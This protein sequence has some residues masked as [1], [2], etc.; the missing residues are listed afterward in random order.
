MPGCPTFVHRFDARTAFAGPFR[1]GIS[2]H[3]HTMYSKE[4]LGRL[5]T[6]IAKF[7]IGGYIIEREL[8]RLHLYQHW[9]F[10]FNRIY[11]TPPLSPREAHKLESE[12][13]E[14]QL[15]LEALVSLSDH[16]SIEAG[17]HLR[18]LEG[19]ASAPI[20]V[21]W[22]VPFE[23]T[24]FHIGVHNLPAGSAMAWMT[25]LGSFTAKPDAKQLRGILSGL[26]SEKSVLVVLNHPY[27]D[28]ES[29]GPERHKRALRSFL[30]KFLPQVHAIEVNGMRSRKENREVL[31][32]G[33]VLGIPVI[34][35]GDR[36]GL[37]ANAVLNVSP[38]ESFEEFVEE[39]REEK[40]SEIVLMPQYF[41][42]LPLRLIEN[43]WHALS[44]APG[45]FGRGHWMTRVFFEQKGEAQALSQFTGTRFHHV[46]DKF[47]WVIS[48]V[49]NP[50]LR[51]AVRL[52]FLGHE[53]GGL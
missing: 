42:P 12:Q 5:P 40:R 28:A 4:Y 32:L 25:E 31:Q 9:N 52:P 17:M 3:S 36:H 14:R 49:A 27:W 6:Y 34:S 46:V 51:L 13:I 48:L 15:G 30:S 45:E 23:D 26:E 38:A 29:I 39:V 22:T 50:V 2:L 47:R 37:E 1:S 7:P 8:G 35:G 10:D 41:E 11:W 24:V 18:M 43:A 16:D 19:T 20:S 33:A 53:E 21:E 44:D